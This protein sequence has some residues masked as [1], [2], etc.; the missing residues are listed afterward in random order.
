MSSCT[1][2][3]K[4]T[5]AD[6]LE[7][8]NADNIK[9]RYEEAAEFLKNSEILE[10]ET[11]FQEFYKEYKYRLLQEVS[12]GKDKSLKSIKEIYENF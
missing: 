1:L 7:T 11:S 4:I 8:E 10:K 9:D 5:G 2:Q 12:V 3:D 6:I